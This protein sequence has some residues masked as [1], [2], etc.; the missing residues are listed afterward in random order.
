VTI[1][2]RTGLDWTSV[3]PRLAAA[4]DIPVDRASSM[5]KSSGSPD[6]SIVASPDSAVLIDRLHQA[7]HRQH[8]CG[9][10]AAALTLL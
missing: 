2:T 10:A 5:A 8:G 9:N 1:R 6:N 4:F 7:D 3:L